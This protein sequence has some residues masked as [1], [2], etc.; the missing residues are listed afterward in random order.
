M[1]NVYLYVFMYVL[2][3]CIYYNYF[4]LNINTYLDLYNIKGICYI[5]LVIKN[6]KS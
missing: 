6:C 3:L 1:K 5:F 2:L 4:F